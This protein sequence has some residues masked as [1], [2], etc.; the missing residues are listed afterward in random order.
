M[1]EEGALK[2]LSSFEESFQM[3]QPE[4]GVVSYQNFK[5]VLLERSEKNGWPIPEESEIGELFDL[6][7]VRN[8]H[9]LTFT[10]FYETVLGE[11]YSWR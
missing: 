4:E 8:D 2:T 10:D 6:A 11:K 9:K 3:F 1:D 5:R 7:D